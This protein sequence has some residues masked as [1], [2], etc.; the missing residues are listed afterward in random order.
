MKDALQRRLRHT[1]PQPV[2]NRIELSERDF[3]IFA[4]I[5]RH[6]PLPAPYLFALTKHLCKN[7][8]ATQHRLTKLY[9]GTL[10]SP[11]LLSRPSQQ[12]ASF[13]ARYQPLVYDL[14]P[15]AEKLLAGR[16]TVIAKRGDPFV[17]RLMTACVTASIEL[18]CKQRGLRYIPQAEILARNSSKL[19]LP[20]RHGALIPDGL[21]GI[22]YPIGFLFFAVELDRGT[23]SIHRSNASQTGFGGKL[24][25]YLEV[26]ESRS[27]K[28]H[29]G[30]PNLMV[31][32]VTTSASRIGN[33]AAC[34]RART[35][36]KQA[37]RFLFRTKPEFGPNWSVPAVM[38]DLLSEPWIRAGQPFDLGR[39]LASTF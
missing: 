28:T 24:E 8:T 9:N 7:E 15:A 20:L 36:E 21:F 19:P 34:L 18:G 38:D 32:T 5:N 17:H 22:E 3:S 13:K 10:T 2:G 37:Q 1:K 25:S 14:T 12:F 39:G 31:L 26:F 23:E 6:G 11:P 35:D 29:W 33:I 16:G 4:A 30:I 27:F